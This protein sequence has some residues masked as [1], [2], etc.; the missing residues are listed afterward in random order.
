MVATTCADKPSSLPETADGDLVFRICSAPREGQIVRLKSTKCTIGSGP[1]CTL[2]L[3]ASGVSPLHCL[4]VRG[5]AVTVVRRWS[6]DTRLNDRAFTDAELLPGDRLG[7]GSVDLEVV[8]VQPSR[9]MRGSS[10]KEA[11]VLPSSD[12]SLERLK[13]EL[14]QQRR[15]WEQQHQQWQSQQG[16]AMAKLAAEREQFAEERHRLETEKQKL[17]EQRQQWESE[18]QES[19]A[20]LAS[21][22]E[23]FSVQQKSF[24]AETQKLAEQ[25][26]QWE[27]EH[28]DAVAGLANQTEQ[29]SA[30]Q[31]HLEAERQALA[32]QRRQW[33]LEHQETISGLA[34]QNEQISAALTDLQAQKEALD[35]QRR[36]MDAQAQQS[37]AEVVEQSK[38]R[39]AESAEAEAERQSLDRQRQ[40]WQAEQSDARQQLERQRESLDA[41]TI[42]LDAKQ[43][44]L[45]A[46]EIELNAKQKALDEQETE[47]DAKKTALD[48][49]RQVLE[50]QQAEPTPEPAATESMTSEPS[51]E[52]SATTEREP[53]FESPG[54]AAPVDLA[55][56]FRRV[57]A[58]VDLVDEAQERAIEP[59]PPVDV[60]PKKSLETSTVASGKDE[61]SID[62][63]MNRLMKRL[64]STSGDADSPAYAPQQSRSVRIAEEAAGLPAAVKKPV[65][66]APVAADDAKLTELSSPRTVAPERNV[67][68]SALRELANLSAQSAISQ[69]ARQVLMQ[70]MYSKLMVTLV[71]LAAGATLLWMWKTLGAAQTTFYAGLVALLVAIYW[72]ME[73]ALLSGRLTISKTGHIEIDWNRSPAHKSE[74]ADRTPK[75]DDTRP[76]V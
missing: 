70:A 54:A 32:E 6:P 33:E 20:Q 31:E 45:D 24:D 48:E 12:V 36:R 30:E 3:R 65:V 58:T 53:E 19:A 41:Q 73:Y 21:Q 34:T 52:E 69:H 2:R 23:Q 35:E 60:E 63:Y 5:P 22:A 46:Q 17:A 74:T 11:A 56:V 66:P 10:P 29:I 50:P 1:R 67:D 71:A 57:G 16:E 44:A 59:A 64:R 42:E 43:K 26:R 55:E 8:A 4:I 28:Q 15:Q 38:R 76:P 47:L 49:Q 18:H 61:E 7:I 25:R 72:G 14:E 13:Q 39:A 27:S 62:D 9:N 75:A 37:A 51:A 68:L 40:Q